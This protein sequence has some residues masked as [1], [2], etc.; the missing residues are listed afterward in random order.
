MKK[1]LR[2]GIILV[3]IAIIVV[4]GMRVIK[5][6]RADEAKLPL[7]VNYDMLIKTISPTPKEV[8]LSLPYLALTKSNDDV[9]I[10]SR[11]SGRIQSI[12]KSGSIVK[13]GDTILKIDDQELKTQRKSINLNIDTLKSQYHAKKVALKNLEES[14]QRTQKLLAVKG[15]SKEA[16]DKEVSNIVATKSALDALKFKIQ[17]LQ[18]SRASIDNMLSY[19]TIKSPIDGIVTKL[20]NIGD[21]AFMGKPLI[22]ISAKS[23]SYLLVRLPSDIKPKAIIYNKKSYPLSALNTTDNGLLEYLANIDA[24]VVSNQSV[25]IDVVIFHDKGILLPHDA[26]LNRNGH[27]A[28][29]VLKNHKAIAK[30]VMILANGEQGV[31]VDG[32]HHDEKIIV[33]KQDILLKLLGGVNA[34]AEK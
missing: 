23:S 6:K 25:N 19:A 29:L 16:F 27:S 11:I 17:E 26:I 8:T 30:N 5:A 2:Y 14:H 18:S 12:V 22:S 1:L 13:K 34:R 10:S 28:V 20:A 3:V 21:V 31:I 24:H 32:V 7:A 33:A 9:K 15:A 4:L